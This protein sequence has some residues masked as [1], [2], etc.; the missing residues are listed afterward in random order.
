[1]T[2]YAKQTLSLGGS[3]AA[4]FISLLVVTFE[5]AARARDVTRPRTIHATRIDQIPE[6]DG[7]LDDACWQ[8]AEPIGDFTVWNSEI[9]AGGENL[10]RRFHA[11]HRRE[12]PAA[13]RRQTQV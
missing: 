1:M 4:L 5:Q 12:V 8:Q 9:P 3:V 13:A 6:I 10:L 7:R 11:I 2:V